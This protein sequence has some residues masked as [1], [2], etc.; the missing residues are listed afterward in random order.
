M[1]TS[2]IG[3]RSPAQAQP[4][5]GRTFPA[6]A[7][8]AR[9]TYFDDDGV[10]DAVISIVTSLAAEV[11]ALRERVDSLEAVLARHGALDPAEVEAHRPDGEA[12]EARAAEAAAFTS[13]VFRVFE[14]MRE[15]ITNDESEARYAEVVERAFA[16]LEGER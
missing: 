3:A 15:E 6:K 14:E 1:D 16:E 2:S 11:W 12:A 9:P 10:T 8:G 13:R 5:E 4:V 7:K